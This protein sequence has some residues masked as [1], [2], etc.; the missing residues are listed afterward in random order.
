MELKVSRR[1]QA[2]P[3]DIEVLAASIA[4]VQRAS[5]EIPWHVG[6]KTDPWDHVESAI[7]LTIG[8]YFKE[9]RYAFEWLKRNQLDD[10]SWYSAYMEGTPV[11]LTR[12]ANMSSYIAVG[13]FHY[14]L[15]TKDRAFLSHMWPSM[16]AG[17]DFALSLQAPG[18]EIYWAKSPQ[19]DVDPM[20]LLTGSSSVFMSVKCA[21]AIVALLGKEKPAWQR[22]LSRLGIA[23]RTRPDHFNREKTRYSM[24]W[25]YP[26]LTGAVVGRGALT[27]MMQSWNTFVVPGL[28]VRCVCDEPWVTMAETSELALALAAM[29]YGKLAE[30]L[31]T[32]IKDNTHDDGTY[33][34]GVTFPKGEIW[35]EEKITWTNAAVM[36]AA[37][38]VY[39]LTPASHLFNH[40]FWERHATRRSQPA[41]LSHKEVSLRGMEEAPAE[42]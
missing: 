14:Y 41:Y 9:A 34:C 7:G 2:L 35:P 19:G 15:V 17:I 5:G 39:N 24:D 33:W 22:S 23:V 13:L 1:P 29:N 31:L 18:G 30:T 32:W 3:F 38:A 10:G 28:G 36:M 8:G 6:G 42:A 26:V 11:D 25:F 12:E 27:R 40:T 21:L 37:D 20:A 16:A 4:D